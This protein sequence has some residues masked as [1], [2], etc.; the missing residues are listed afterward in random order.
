MFERPSGDFQAA[1]YRP[2]GQTVRFFRPRDGADWQNVLRWDRHRL[3]TTASGFLLERP[4]GVDERYDARGRLNQIRSADDTVTR[5]HYAASGLLARVVDAFGNELVFSY[6]ASKQLAAVRLPNSAR[7][8]RYSYSGARLVRVR[9]PGGGQRRYLYQDARFTAALTGIIDARGVRLSTTHYDDRGRA[10]ATR[11]AGAKDRVEL[12]YGADG[13][14]SVTDL[15]KSLTRTYHFVVQHGVRKVSRIVGGG[16]ASG[17]ASRGPRA[18]QYDRDGR[19]V[20]RQDAV[21]MRTRFEYD[22][23]GRVSRVREAAGL[24]SA[25]C[26]TLGW[27]ARGRLT[28]HT[29]HAGCG[30][31]IR[32]TIYQRDGRGRLV[33]RVVRDAANSRRRVVRYSY[34]ARSQLIRV[35]GPRSDAFDVTLLRYNARG[36]L[37]EVRR[38]RTSS[39]AGDLVTRLSNH[40][41]DGRP[42]R[43]SLPSGQ[44][45][46][47]TFS[48][49]GWL[50]SETRDGVAWRFRRDADGRPVELLLPDGT[51]DNWG[52][53]AAVRR[54]YSGSGQLTSLT[55]GGQRALYRYDAADQLREALLQRRVG[56]A[57]QTVSR[58]GY[59]YRHDAGG[60]TVQQLV[61]AAVDAPPVATIEE[62][63][64]A[65]GLVVEHGQRTADGLAERTRY[66]YDSLKRLVRV[67]DP[68]GASTELRYDW[69]GKL[70]RV[71]DAKGVETRFIRD[72]FGNIVRRESPDTGV[73]TYAYDPAGNLL[74]AS[75]GRGVVRE[76]SYDAL[77][78]LLRVHYP[79]NAA[80][81]A[82]Y[83]YDGAAGLGRLG[84]VRDRTGTTSY[85]YDARGQLTSVRHQAPGGEVRTL[86][87]AYHPL[88]AVSRITYPNGMVVDYLRDRYGD[89][90]R[91]R[92]RRPGAPALELAQIWRHPFGPVS[93]IRFGLTGVDNRRAVDAAYRLTRNSYRRIADGQL[94]LD[95][96]LDYDGSGR[97][98]SIVDPLDSSV[99]ESFLYDPAG[100][101]ID[102][103]GSYGR[104]VYRYD[105]VGNR[106]TR[107]A[108][109]DRDAGLEQDASRTVRV[110]PRPPPA[111]AHPRRQRRALALRLRRGGQHGQPR[112]RRRRGGSAP[113][114]AL[115]LWS[116][117]PPERGRSLSGGARR[118]ATRELPPRRARP[119]G[120]SSVRPERAA[121]GRR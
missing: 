95:R 64:R 4:D 21:G 99:N 76:L 34:N 28:R 120:P 92:L 45:I 89:T 58:R 50:A 17:C 72:P 77:G 5:L 100:R 52:D 26:S 108:S 70:T 119:P 65:D 115:L 13:T 117:W 41:A 3:S 114:S 37:S 105:A 90:S 111:V 110:P 69:L 12:S 109:G 85:G 10:V 83:S 47:Q 103:R 98:A 27:D 42:R 60:L 121:T 88:G 75:D 30:G 94:L 73:S 49:R 22:A 59:R 81:D 67:T 6:N 118:Q 57:W 36:F 25:R 46:E 39:R 14:T 107:H 24:P 86:G 43:I 1:A 15:S 56:A 63:F 84:Q 82:R 101:L 116:G 9:Y 16:C 106:L 61:Y 53:N 96:R 44:V 68:V 35:D 18:L 48:A 62:R 7:R 97:V 112:S 23:D 80:Y 20:L 74:R 71:I 66:D 54:T 19:I 102:A 51:P 55:A 11:R 93:R 2:N 78:R 91:V 87:Y 31:A 8:L 38:A 32:H 79:G 33:G 29:E 113:S 104:R 40:D